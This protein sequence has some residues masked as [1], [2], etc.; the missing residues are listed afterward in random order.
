[1][2][3][4]S[5]CQCRKFQVEIDN[6]MFYIRVWSDEFEWIHDLLGGRAAPDVEEVCRRSP[7]QLN[8]VHTANGKGYI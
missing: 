4:L 6:S 2:T 8:N 5:K 1:M 7:V 3:A